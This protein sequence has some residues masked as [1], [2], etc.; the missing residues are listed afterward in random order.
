[1]DGTTVERSSSIVSEYA[2]SAA[3]SCHSPCSLA[4]ASTRATCCVVAPGHPQV[5]DGLVVDREDG[6]GGAVL[7]AHVADG[8]AVGQRHRRD[9]L[10]VELDELADDAVLAQHLGDGEHQVGR[11]RTLGQRADQLEADDLRDE[12]RHGLAEHRGLRLDAADAPPEHPE[13]VDH[14]GVRVGADQG[15]RVGHAVPLEHDPGQVLDVDLVHDPGA[16]RHDLEVV[17]GGLAPAQELV[18]LGV[19]LVLELDVALEGVGSP[20]QVGDHR[21]V[22]HQLGGR[23]RVDPRGVAAELLDGLAHGGQVDHA[24][25]AGEVLHHDPGG[26][27]LDLGVRLRRGSHAA[28]ARTWSAVMFA[29]SSVRSRF[30]SRIFSEYGSF[31]GALHLVQPVDLV[32]RAAHLQRALAAEAVRPDIALTAARHERL[33]SSSQLT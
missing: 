25:D 19:A 13:P 29:P 3:G 1:M 14:R 18:A 26:G 7:R 15:V 24:G 10:A 2:G 8:G 32:R 21:V 31:C 9:A 20:E 27:E 5:A 23:Q 4:Y 22:D 16:R 28:S 11:G 17:E 12:H 30:S 6:H 33:L